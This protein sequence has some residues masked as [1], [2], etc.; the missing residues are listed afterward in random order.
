MHH[1]SSVVNCRNFSQN[2][3]KKNVLHVFTFSDDGQLF[4][5][6][7]NCA[8]QL[9]LNHFDDVAVFTYV[10]LPTV[11]VHKVSLGWDFTTILAGKAKILF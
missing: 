7:S 8:G 11:K 5:C 1:P 4:T 6:G 10:N 9:G 3:S 2:Y